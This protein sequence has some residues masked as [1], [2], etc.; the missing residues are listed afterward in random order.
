MKIPCLLAQPLALIISGW[1]HI[2]AGGY[3]PR[4]ARPP[5]RWRSTREGPRPT[6]D[7]LGCCR[8]LRLGERDGPD[9]G[10]RGGRG[11][12]VH[13]APCQQLPIASPRLPTPCKDGVY[14]QKGRRPL[15]GPW[16]RHSN[17]LLFGPSP[18]PPAGVARKN[19]LASCVWLHGCPAP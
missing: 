19:L 15:V 6:C 9:R 1:P 17:N 16:H 7:C 13:C 12:R 10:A 11:G 8:P 3:L 2:A 5:P 14:S 4:C 18:P